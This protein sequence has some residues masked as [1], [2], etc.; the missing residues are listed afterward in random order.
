VSISLGVDVSRLWPVGSTGLCDPFQIGHVVGGS[1][2]E[3]V[4][5]RRD[6]NGRHRI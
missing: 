3:Q 2:P 5:W 1:R 6:R 4:I